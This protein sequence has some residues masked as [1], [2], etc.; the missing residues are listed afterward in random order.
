MV[1]ATKHVL[2]WP[3]AGEG[4]RS[5]K[6]G[7]DGSSQ[8]SALAANNPGDGESRRHG[9][10]IAPTARI[11]QDA[12]SF[13]GTGLKRPVGF[14]VSALLWGLTQRSIAGLWPYGV[15]TMR[16]TIAVLA[17]SA[18]LASAAASFT[19]LPDSPHP[20]PPQQA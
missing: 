6:S 14:R 13:S 8:R 2:V 1:G 18:V 17:F 19:V 4:F 20:A 7:R 12:G 15:F 10:I 5:V 9:R 3:Q 11:R 16:R